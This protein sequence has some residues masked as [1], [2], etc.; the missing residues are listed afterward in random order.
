KYIENDGFDIIEKI[1]IKLNTESNYNVIQSMSLCQ[2]EIGKHFETYH[3]DAVIVLG[4]R[5]E[6]F[7]A[8]TAAAMNNIPI[9]HL[10]GG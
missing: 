3:Y 5:F 2:N 10:H 6:I 7:A 4:D 9:I 1:D 8:S